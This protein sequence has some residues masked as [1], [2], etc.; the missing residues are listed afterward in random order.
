M[1][2]NVDVHKT[3]GAAALI[4]GL[5]SFGST[6]CATDDLYG[7]GA[8][9]VENPTTITTGTPGVDPEPEVEPDPVPWV[10]AWTERRPIL[11][12]PAPVDCSATESYIGEETFR[13][14]DVIWVVDSSGSMGWENQAVQDNLN[15]FSQDIAS[16]GIDHHVVLIG[17]S[18]YIQVPS[19][20]GGSPQFRHVDV[21]VGSNEALS[22]L[23]DRYAQYADML[24]PDSIK[25][26]VAVTDDESDLSASDFQTAIAALSA[27]GFGDDWIFHSIV[28]FG[29]IPFIGCLSGAWVGAHYLSLSGL[30]LGETAK[31]CETNWSPIFTAIVQNVAQAAALPCEFAIPTVPLTGVLDPA[32]TELIYTPGGSMPFGVP[33]IAD[34][35]SCNGIGW[36]YD[37]AA[38][39]TT[40]V[41]CP[42]V[43]DILRAD[44]AGVIELTVTCLP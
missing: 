40:V 39:P 9:P 8:D 35:A 6:G 3:L 21:D 4:F 34:A 10:R 11:E 28:A 26:F 44:S 12:P 31:V 19:P 13:P 38:A 30:S 1:F 41:A 14:T 22:M 33:Q 16:A 2:M 15:Q 20:L 37:D 7:I 18:G 36:H 5:S 17:D 29:Q 42:V 24:R 43:C 32:A 23:V 25:H 27:P